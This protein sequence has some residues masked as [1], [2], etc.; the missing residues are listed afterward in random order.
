MPPPVSSNGNRLSADPA[1]SSNPPLQNPPSGVWSSDSDSPK[2]A[3][4]ISPSIR[5]DDVAGTECSA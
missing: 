5:G 3:E 4:S 1:S 2:Y